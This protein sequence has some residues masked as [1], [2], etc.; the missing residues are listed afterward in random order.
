MAS[1]VGQSIKVVGLKKFQAKLGASAG[2]IKK[3]LNDAIKISIFTLLRDL[4]TGGYV[5]VRTGF[6]RQSIKTSFTD[7]SG[8]VIPMANYA[9]YV[10]EGARGRRAQPFLTMAT[11]RKEREIEKIFEES[12]KKIVNELVK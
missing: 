10:H 4:K 2:L 6:L 7:L 1:N 3:N 12:A 5:P 11:K 8:Y 9:I